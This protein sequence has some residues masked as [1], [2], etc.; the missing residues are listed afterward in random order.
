MP[1]GTRSTVV[2]TDAG[3]EIRGRASWRVR[4]DPGTDMTLSKCMEAEM[5]LEHG[6]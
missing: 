3:R 5:K 2:T 1:E 4:G 6:F